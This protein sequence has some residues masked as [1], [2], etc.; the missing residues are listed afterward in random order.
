[1]KFTPTPLAGATIVDIERRE[2]ARGWFGRSY[3]EHEFEAH[4]LPTRMVQ[5]NTSLTRKRGTLR[6]MHYQL[7]PNAEDKLVRCVSGAI[8]DAIVDIR[9]ESPTYCQWTGVELSA[10]NARMLLVPK[11]FA[12]GFVT[13]TDDAVVTYQVSA[14]Y[15]PASERGA[16]HDDPAFGIAWPVPVLDLSDK[17]RNWPD[18][19]R[20]R[21]LA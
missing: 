20:E 5:T 7:A 14:F 17:D 15:A 11:G 10:D 4:G 8:W 9:P 18:F 12:H 19:A 16:R 13:L 3:C 6:G 2:D 21:T 1:M